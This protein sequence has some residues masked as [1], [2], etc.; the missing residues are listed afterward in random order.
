MAWPARVVCG[1]WISCLYFSGYAVTVYD[2]I[3][4]VRQHFPED[5]AARMQCAQQVA[6]GSMTVCNCMSHR[7]SGPHRV[8]PHSIRKSTL[9]LLSA[10]VSMWYRRAGLSADTPLQRRYNPCWHQVWLVLTVSGIAPCLHCGPI[11]SDMHSEFHHMDT[12]WLMPS[13][14]YMVYL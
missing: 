9:S 14:C 8:G 6:A 5:A 1:S 3:S 11:I 13:C 12:K 7:P 2:G 4:H 10:R